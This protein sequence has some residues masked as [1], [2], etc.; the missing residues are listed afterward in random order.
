MASSSGLVFDV[1]SISAMRPSL[2]VTGS[3]TAA[4]PGRPFKAALNCWS[5]AASTGRLP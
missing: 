3:A 2:E 4:T 1:T 5:W